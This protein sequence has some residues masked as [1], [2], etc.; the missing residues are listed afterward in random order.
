MKWMWKIITVWKMT[1]EREIIT[2]SLSLL[3]G[4]SWGRHVGRFKGAGAQPGL[5]SAITVG[6][7]LPSQD[8]FM[9]MEIIMYMINRNDNDNN[10][11]P[12]HSLTHS[13]TLLA[14]WS[15]G[16]R[17]GR[18]KAQRA[19]PGLSSTVR[20]GW[21]CPVGKWHGGRLKAQR[22]QPEL[23]S[24]GRSMWGCPVGKWLRKWKLN[25]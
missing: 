24:A 21:G 22:A 8:V 20:S 14:G 1:M 15:W 4:W 7:G 16:R 19:Q 11:L 6:V 25:G 18:L 5:S 9:K 12:A 17:G 3:A 10:H 2:G 13:L 23:S